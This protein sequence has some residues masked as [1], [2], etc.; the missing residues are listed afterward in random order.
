M[1]T[2]T[3]TTLRLREVTFAYRAGT[4]DEVRV[5]DGVDLEVA[6]GLLTV[7][8][9]RS[10]SGKTTLLRI[11]SGLILPSS[12]EVRWGYVALQDLD[13]DGRARWRREN[14]GM[15]TQGG[16][17]IDNLTA[18]ENVLLP[19]IGRRERGDVERGAG[20]LSRVRLAHRTRHFPGQLSTGEQQRVSIARALYNDP[21]LLIADE[22]TAN[23]DRGNADDVAGLLVAL[24]AD[25]AVLVATHDS[26][27]IERADTLLT[28]D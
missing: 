4:P 5:L 25:R 20:L 10:G 11:A 2:T 28:L 9:G 18:V 13:E 12:G 3:A 19:G 17:L 22:P 26:E 1:T 6:P 16:G 27:L 23:L 21:G 7:V 8:A 15:A 24:A 14:V